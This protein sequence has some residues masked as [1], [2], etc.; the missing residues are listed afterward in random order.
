M[1]K[2]AERRTG[3][4]ELPWVASVALE[5]IS[6]LSFEGFGRSKSGETNGDSKCGGRSWVV[7]ELLGIAELRSPKLGKIDEVGGPFGGFRG[8]ARVNRAHE[9]VWSAHYSDPG[10]VG[11]A[12][13]RRARI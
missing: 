12:E 8:E 7:D 13:G 9:R 2:E 1:W 4:W 10:E 11:G 3:T 6:T 5:A